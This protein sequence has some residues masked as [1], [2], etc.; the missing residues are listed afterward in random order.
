MKRKTSLLII[1][2]AASGVMPGLVAGTAFAEDKPITEGPSLTEQGEPIVPED[3]ISEPIHNEIEIG[4]GYVSDDAYK[5]GRY[6]GMYE[7]GPFVIGDI[8]IREFDEDGRFWRV[9]G[10]NLGLE[11]RYLRLDGGVQ[12]SYKFFLEYDELPNYKNN[13]VKSPFLGIGGDLLTLSSGFDINNLDAYLKDFELETKRRRA[14]AGVSFIP[15]ES[16]QFDFDVSHENKQ[17][18]DA[19]GSASVSFSDPTIGRTGNTSI[20][21][22]PEPIDQDTDIVNA[23]LSYAGDDGQVDLKYE[24]SMFDNNYSA[25]TWQG[26]SVV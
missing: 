18:V 10:T 14:K 13:T 20:S 2:L 24:M 12:G 23:K 19:T 1:Y 22:L 5:F 15:K 11:S 3:I 21:I 6:N 8:N 16:W 25:L 26:K 9:R 7:K 4:I 17:G